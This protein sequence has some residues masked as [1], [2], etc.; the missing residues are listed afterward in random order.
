MTFRKFMSPYEAA[1]CVGKEVNS[2]GN[3]MTNTLG[4]SLIRFSDV[5][6]MKA[7]ALIWKNGEGDN[8]AKQL[9]NRIR[10]RARLPENSAATKEQLKNERRVELAG[11]FQPSRHLDVVRWGDAKTA[12]NKPTRGVTFVQGTVV[13]APVTV[14]GTVEIYGPRTF[15]PVTNHVFPIPEQA[16]EGTVNLKQNIG[17]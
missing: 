10:K 14:T 3:F 13:D 11:E 1:D 6:L 4:T 17:Y 16:F 12:Y 15:N 9:L 2:N 7:E 8:E 5:L